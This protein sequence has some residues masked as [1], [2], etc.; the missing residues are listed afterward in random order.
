MAVG[1]KFRRAHGVCVFQR[2]A[3]APENTYGERPQTWA[4]IAT[5][6]GIVQP[7]NGREYFS[8]SGERAEVSTR[9]RFR[10]DSTLATVRPSDRIQC[11]GR[12]Y[13]IKSIINV[14]ERNRELIFMCSHDAS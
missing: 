4:D 10:F 2:Q 1:T 7:I 8:A 9:F 13:D 12:N 11:S 5:R 3:T 14:D 6:R